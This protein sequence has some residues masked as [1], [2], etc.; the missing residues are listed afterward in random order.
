MG[1]E[2]TA[3]LM[4][5]V[6][7][8]ISPNYNGRSDYL[9]YR[10][11]VKQWINLTSLPSTKRGPALV[12]RLSGESKASA[13]TLV[14]KDLYDEDGVDLLLVHLDKSF[15]VDPVNEMNADLA[16]FLDFPWRQEISVEQFIA[17]FN[18]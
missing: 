6:S 12:G 10:D 13:G 1:P 17:G 15:A 5:K 14:I 7:N 3:A 8:K 2:D 16:T 9:S 18:S 11:D 4:G